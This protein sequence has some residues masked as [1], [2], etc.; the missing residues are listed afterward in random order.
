MDNTL[1]REQAGT[2]IKDQSTVLIIFLSLFGVF[3]LLYSAAA[4]YAAAQLRSQIN[5]P[6]AQITTTF[7]QGID[8]ETVTESHTNTQY[9]SLTVLY[10]KFFSGIFGAAVLFA[11]VSLFVMIRK[12]GTPFTES[13]I[14]RMYIISALLLSGTVLSPVLAIA[15]TVLS[16]GRAYAKVMF[17]DMGLGIVLAIV[18]MALIRIFRYGTV[19][20]QESDETL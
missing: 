15:V 8:G 4:M 11:A 10:E 2:K 9:A 14:K 16:Q 7:V 3:M 18:V 1:T 6:D 5:D 17:S 19:L 20:Q 13:V 12:T